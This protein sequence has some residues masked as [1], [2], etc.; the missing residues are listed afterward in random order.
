MLVMLATGMLLSE[1]AVLPPGTSTSTEKRQT[2]G[3][4]AVPAGMLPAVI[5]VVPL[6]DVAL[7]VA[8]QP[9]PEVLV[10]GVAATCS[11]CVPVG[12]TSLMAKFVNAEVVLLLTVKVSVT[13]LPGAAVVGLKAL[14]TVRPLLVLTVAAGAPSESVLG[15]LGALAVMFAVGML[16]V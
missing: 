8:E 11:A 16:L 2:K 13:V 1:V 9:V 5:P 7:N 10:A 14:A 6:P 15:P 4:A 12:N 3:V